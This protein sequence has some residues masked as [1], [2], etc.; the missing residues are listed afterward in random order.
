MAEVRFN[1]DDKFLENLQSQL[2]T[3]KSTDIMREALTVLNW[4]VGERSRGRDIL[5]GDPDASNL[6]RL[7]TPGLESVKKSASGV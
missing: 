6:T 5:S 3:S 4:A 2:G 1:V 7:A